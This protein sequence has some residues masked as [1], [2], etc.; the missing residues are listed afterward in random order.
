MVVPAFALLKPLVPQLEPYGLG[1]IYMTS[2]ACVFCALMLLFQTIPWRQIEACKIC[3]RLVC[4]SWCGGSLGQL[5]QFWGY[6]FNRELSET[7]FCFSLRR[8]SPHEA[9]LPA[10]IR[11]YVR[12]C[13]RQFPVEK[14]TPKLHNLSQRTAT[15]GS[16]NEQSEISHPLMARSLNRT[17]CI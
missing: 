8:Y 15:P 12:T 10:Y 1:N 16:A 17:I 6:F 7:R 13:F 9:L 2:C 14:I 3:Q 5:V 11:T 4:A